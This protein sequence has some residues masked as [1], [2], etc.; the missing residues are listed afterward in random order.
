[1]KG[2]DKMTLIHADLPDVDIGEANYAGPYDGSEIVTLGLEKHIIALKKR[3]AVDMAYGILH[4]ASEP[5][6][7]QQ[8]PIFDWKGVVSGFLLVSCLTTYAWLIWQ[9]LTWWIR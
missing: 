7:L 1:M 5:T 4:V 9:G 8:T 3:D 6:P 2:G